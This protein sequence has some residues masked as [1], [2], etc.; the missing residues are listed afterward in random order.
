MSECKFSKIPWSSYWG[1]LAT[2]CAH[3]T[4][5]K[6]LSIKPTR[7]QHKL[8]SSSWKTI[9]A[10]S[11]TWSCLF[12]SPRQPLLRQVWGNNLVWSWHLF[13]LSFIA[14]DGRLILNMFGCFLF[15]PPLGVWRLSVWEFQEFQEL[16]LKEYFH[17]PEA[18]STYIFLLDSEISIIAAWFTA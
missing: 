18:I 3:L 6:I 10:W 15:N 5:N 14:T 4:C 2:Q 8:T 7:Y 16:N 1:S 12:D 9:H 17:Q 13:W 11:M